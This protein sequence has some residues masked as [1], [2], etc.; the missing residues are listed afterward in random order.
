[1]GLHDLLAKFT[2]RNPRE[3]LF[4]ATAWLKGLDGVLEFVGGATL[5]AVGPAVIVRVVHSL[6]VEEITEDQLSAPRGSA[7][8]HSARGLRT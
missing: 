3:L 2:R 8:Q 1:M 4:R 6:T 7:S 5:L